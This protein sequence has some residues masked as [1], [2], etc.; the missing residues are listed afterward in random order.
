MIRELPYK[1]L[2]I[3]AAGA[4]VFYSVWAYFAND[5]S[6]VRSSLMQGSMS[7]IVTFFLA[8][9][10]EIIY[11]KATTAILAVLL[12]LLLIWSLMSVQGIVHYFIGTDHVFMTILPGLILGTIYVVVYLLDLEKRSKRRVKINH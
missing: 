12:A 9:M 10:L 2:F 8:M 11:K 5:G 7:F 3:N 6:A 1:K 4:F